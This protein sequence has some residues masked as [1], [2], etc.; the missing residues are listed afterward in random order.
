MGRNRR[1][2]TSPPYGTTP[3]SIRVLKHDEQDTE[4]KYLSDYLGSLQW[5]RKDLNDEQIDDLAQFQRPRAGYQ[6][7][8]HSGQSGH[9]GHWWHK[10]KN[11]G[12]FQHP[13]GAL[14]RRK[15]GG[16]G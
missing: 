13:S 11:G 4:Q 9:S 14:G 2:R 10:K 15:D 7:G 5:Q 12:T 1:P 3:H 8:G 6:G 16:F